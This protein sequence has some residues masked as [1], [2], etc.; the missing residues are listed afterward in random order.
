MKKLS[1]GFRGPVP[2]GVGVVGDDV[3]T[4]GHQTLVDSC[5]EGV[6]LRRPEDTLQWSAA[7]LCHTLCTTLQEQGQQGPYDLGRVQ[8]LRP[9]RRHEQ[10]C[11]HAVFY[12]LK[13]ILLIKS[14]YLHNEVL[15][16]TN[17]RQKDVF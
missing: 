7:D 17:Q 6:R 14:H 10:L 4:A 1:V 5:E 15:D 12:V 8:L 16:E 13:I 11:Y 3:V 2:V 9:E